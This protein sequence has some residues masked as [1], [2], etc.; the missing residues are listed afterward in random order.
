MFSLRVSIMRKQDF[1]PI[2]RVS[3]TLYLH[4]AKPAQQRSATEKRP[5]F[6][7]EVSH[8]LKYSRENTL[9]EFLIN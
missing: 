4:F 7:P 1:W 5:D 9:G 3:E 6:R 8:R 2:L